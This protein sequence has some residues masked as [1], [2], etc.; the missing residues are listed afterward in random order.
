MTCNCMAN[1]KVLFVGESWQ[2]LELHIKGFDMFHR[3]EYEEG[4]DHLREALAAENIEVDYMPSHLAA[5]DFPES[6]EAISQY[7]VVLLSDIGYNTLA[8]PPNTF[9]QFKR[10]PN[11]LELLASYVEAGGSMLMIGGYMSFQ[12]IKCQGGYRNTPI[13]EI[14]PVSLNSFDDRVER[15]EGV[16]PELTTKEHQITS[17]LPTEWPHF[18]GYNQVTPDEDGEILAEINDDPLLVVGEYGQGRTAAFTSDC[19]PHWG[20]PAF[21][22]WEDYSTLWTNIVTWLAEA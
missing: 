11:R 5:D 3:A 15:S 7:D 12:G 6:S 14:L 9:N 8:I 20:S 13:E 19:A 4:G 17:D 22:D 18:L 2:T 21:V 16:I 1:H 10:R